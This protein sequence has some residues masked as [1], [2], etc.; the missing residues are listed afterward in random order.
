[1]KENNENNGIFMQEKN[2]RESCTMKKN[3]VKSKYKI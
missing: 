1:M 2:M 3:K